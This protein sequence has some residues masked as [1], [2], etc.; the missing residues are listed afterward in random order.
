MVL[1]M[2]YGT[3]AQGQKKWDGGGGT[4]DWSN[5][6]NWFPDGVPGAGD[7]VLLNNELIIGSYS[8]DLPSGSSTVS[9][10]TLVIQPTEG[11]II[12]SLPS[13]NH[14]NPGLSL[15]GAGDALTLYPGGVFRNASGAT[16]GSGILVNG[17]I[18]IN[19]GGKYIHQT[20]R[21]NAGI[22]DKL[23]TVAGT[24]GGIF[25]FDVPGTAGY[26]VSL[27]GNNFGSLSFS[28]SA[29]G[30]AK[31]YSGSG[32]GT[33]LI[34]GDLAVQANAQLTSTLSADIVIGGSLSVDG[35]LN[36]NPS[37]SGMVSRS[38]RFIGPDA[39]IKGNGTISMNASFRNI[40]VARE[41][42]L[43]VEKQLTLS[44]G[45]HALVCKGVLVLNDQYI[46]GSG[47]FLLLDSATLITGNKNGIASSGASGSVRT[48]IRS[49]SPRAIYMFTGMHLQISGDALPD[50]ISSLGVSNGGVLSLSRNV[51]V[52]DSLRLLKGIIKSTANAM[53]TLGT[54]QIRSPVNAFGNINQGWDSSYVDGQL[55]IHT[56]TGISYPVPIGSG[57][58]YAPVQMTRVDQ[59]EQTVVLKY[60]PNP[61]SNTILGD[62]LQKISNEGHWQFL[63]TPPTNY[64]Y[65]ISYRPLSL[66]TDSSLTLTVGA[67]TG[68]SSTWKAATSKTT[69]GNFGWLTTD[70]GIENI[71]G[72]AVA[73][74]SNLTILP[75][76][77][78]G[79]SGQQDGKQIRLRWIAEENG[80][81]IRY[82][83]E[84]SGDG[85][86]F[87][88]LVTMHSSLRKLA[89]HDFSDQLPLPI[90]YYRLYMDEGGTGTWS[91]TLRFKSADRQLQL[92]PNPAT[93]Q[94]TLNFPASRSKYE[95]EIVSLTGSVCKKFVCNTAKC[96]IRVD[97][98]RKG[99]Y[100][101]RL[102]DQFG[103]ITLPLTKN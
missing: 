76:G 30:S 87:Q 43:S 34:R 84:R 85:R 52:R 64:L 19:D 12:V 37:T 11:T 1:Y 90:N 102:T 81:D 67:L 25:E 97:D 80:K 96:Q 20:A 15:T 66:Y 18:R 42:I 26:T 56:H 78:I 8:V 3:E 4:S 17:T 101:V 31:S 24:E 57:D 29:S 48:A 103:S 22:I 23:S 62:D 35:K 73:A 45:Q 46:D 92:Y 98:L 14:A 60:D 41:A 74:K 95:V 6:L 55:G 33:L 86:N 70:S 39:H 72:L 5:A 44:Q 77:L 50:T 21:S 61:L 59:G 68:G 79:F 2:L 9:I 51:Y 89:Q 88:P 83:L 53:L 91:R 58:M 82:R 54:N 93:G 36:L 49:F 75:M 99:V 32:A 13:G 71:W 65:A 38:L 28:A 94:I 10:P 7:N 27:T 47:S 63:S 100:F 69:G 40:E 16:T